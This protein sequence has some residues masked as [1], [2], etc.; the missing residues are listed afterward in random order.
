MA[1]L[2][3]LSSVFSCVKLILLQKRQKLA[4]NRGWKSALSVLQQQQQHQQLIILICFICHFFLLWLL[5]CRST[6]NVKIC[7]KSSS[8]DKRSRKKLLN[9]EKSQNKKSWNRQAERCQLKRKAAVKE[10][11]KTDLLLTDW[12]AYLQDTLAHLLHTADKLIPVNFQMLF[13]YK[14]SCCWHSLRTTTTT[15]LFLVFRTSKLLC[16]KKESS[17]A[18]LFLPTK[19]KLLQKVQKQK[20]QYTSIELTRR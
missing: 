9:F 1:P 7:K 16:R 5:L 14:S 8:G 18:F 11:G 2:L 6:L 19:N 15:T 4:K 20:K 3:I 13:F 12:V 17:Y 10:K